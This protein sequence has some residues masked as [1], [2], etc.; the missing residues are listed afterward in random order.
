MPF[1]VYGALLAF[2]QAVCEK[3]MAKKFHTEILRV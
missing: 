2:C 1:T 3:I